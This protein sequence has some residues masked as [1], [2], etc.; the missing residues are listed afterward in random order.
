MLASRDWVAAARQ[1][2]ESKASQYSSRDEV[3][4]WLDVAAVLHD[5][6][7][8]RDSDQALDQA[9]QRLEELYTQSIS[10]GAAMFFLND[11]TDDYRGDPH[12][13][14][15]LHILR[16]L[17]YAY[18]GQ[19]DEAV[20][21]SRK[22]SAF[23]AELGPTV[24]GKYAYRDDAFAQYLS[25]LLF[26]DAGRRDDA[27]ISYAAAH[28]AYRSYAAMYG[29]QE[30]SY[31]PGTA[32]PGEGEI[33]FL[34]YVGLAPRRASQTVQIAWNDALAAIRTSGS[35][36][37]N[38]QVKNAITAGL[39]ANAITVAF[40]QHVQDPFA[41]AGSEIEVA[42]RRARTLLVEDISAIA[43]KALDDRMDTIRSRAIARAAIKYVLARLAEDQVTKQAGHGWGFLAGLTARATGAALEIADTRCWSTL[44]AQIRMARVRAPAGTQTVGVRYSS[45]A[46]AFS[47]GES[48]TVEVKP[49]RRTYV[50]VRTAL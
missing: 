21:E 3:L 43:K 28:K 39:S 18:A 20:V 5:G 46:G 41:I 25:A 14:S 24:G 27:R 16:A 36:D 26:E 7:N 13:R 15:L 44:P 34:H 42:G 29:T 4:Y 45:A 8:F 1:L 11:T 38:A 22:V 40:P 17:N 12:E 2:Q 32:A 9:E 49:G 30:P 19:T 47:D 23:L 37:D 48:L 10:K 50:H 35:D 33:V 31:E 6:G